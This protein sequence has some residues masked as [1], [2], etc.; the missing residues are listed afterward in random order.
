MSVHIEYVNSI[1]SPRVDG[2]VSFV[3]H[4]PACL[5]TSSVRRSRPSW[6]RA[7][8]LRVP[9]AAVAKSFE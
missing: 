7:V 6:M 4:D 2:N 1:S 5:V 9:P 8:P 3:D